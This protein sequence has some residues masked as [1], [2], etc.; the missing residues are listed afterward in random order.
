MIL[1]NA[2][3]LVEYSGGWLAQELVKAHSS[4]LRWDEHRQSWAAYDGAKWSRDY[5]VAFQLAAEISRWANHRLVSGCTSEKEL[6]RA[7]RLV[8]RIGSLRGMEEVLRLAKYDK[9]VAVDVVELDTNDDLLGTPD[10]V[11]DLRTGAVSSPE[12]DQMISLNT[13][14]SPIPM[15]TPVWDKFLKD[16]TDGDEELSS[17]LKRM[18]GY[19]LTGYAREQKAIFLWGPTCTGKNTFLGALSAVMGDYARQAGGYMFYKTPARIRATDLGWVAGARLVRGAEVSRGKQWG[20][21]KIE[22]M[23][24]PSPLKG[25]RF[26]GKE[27]SYRPQMLLVFCVNHKPRLTTARD[28][29]L[30]VPFKHKLEVVNMWL[31]E[32]LKAEY[33]GILQWMIEGAQEWYRRGLDA[34][35]VVRDEAVN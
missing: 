14:V 22:L 4:R 30:I 12:P 28:R 24:G 3:Q 10:V 32:Q 18:A 5:R 31:P 29:A 13:A 1:E 21:A 27:F 15:P 7:G 16:V 23:T 33:P 9:S 2:I 17:F 26:Y 6:D 25:R 34:P 20:D 8:R 19:A 35:Q 11:V